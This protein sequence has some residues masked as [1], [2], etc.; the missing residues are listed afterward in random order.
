M[1]EWKWPMVTVRGFLVDGETG[2]ALYVSNFQ[3]L[4]IREYRWDT[5]GVKIVRIQQERR[6]TTRITDGVLAHAGMFDFGHCGQGGECCNIT[7][8]SGSIQVNWNY[9]PILK[10]YSSDQTNYYFYTNITVGGTRSLY[11]NSTGCNF[12]ITALTG[13]VQEGN[14]TTIV[15]QG[16]T[17]NVSVLKIDTYNTIGE[18]GVY[19]WIADFGI[20]GVNASTILPMVNRTSDE[21]GTEWGYMQ[22]VSIFGSYYDV[23]LANESNYT[24]QRCILESL[25]D[26]QC[27]KKAWLVPTSIG[28]FSSSQ[29][30]N[31]TIG[32]NFTTDLYL[33]A[34]GPRDGDGITIGNFSN[35][36]SFG[37]STLPAIGGIPLADSTTSYFNILNETA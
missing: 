18:C 29:T 31:V 15:K 16:K 6:N 9:T 25:P 22:N 35:I 11:K 14:Y 13:G 24:Y 21:W 37:L 33:T 3:P 20:V 1:E 2:E 17:Y 27:V 30:K 36:A 10:E 26:G 34:I 32:Q 8:V 5:S 4:D 19:C 23:I 28:N 12:N 7:D